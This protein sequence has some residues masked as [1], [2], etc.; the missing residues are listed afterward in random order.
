MQLHAV[1]GK[2]L[3]DE[4]PAVT[5]LRRALAA[6]QRDAALLTFADELPH[7][8]PER[9]LLSHAVVACVTLLVVVLLVRGAAAQLL[10]QKS[11]IHPDP[12]EGGLELLAVELWSDARVGVGAHIDDDVDRLAAQQLTQ[13]GERVV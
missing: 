13:A 4:Q 7:G 10:P 11:I 12:R 9:W 8:R 5:L 1:L 3:A 6:H 2:Y